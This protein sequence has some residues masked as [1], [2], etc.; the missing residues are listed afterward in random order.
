M[1]RARMLCLNIGTFH[2]WEAGKAFGFLRDSED[3]ASI[4]CHRDDIRTDDANFIA[5]VGFKVEFDTAVYDGRTKAVNVTLP[6]GGKITARSAGMADGGKPQRSV[7][8]ASNDREMKAILGV[9]SRLERR[10][11]DVSNRQ[12]ILFRAATAIAHK[13]DIVIDERPAAIELSKSLWSD[14]FAER[15]EKATMARES[16]AAEE[17]DNDIV[18]ESPSNNNKSKVVETDMF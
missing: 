8:H 15:R 5:P 2:R 10:V 4:F 13:E 1:F 16:E 11:R 18:K 9:V 3:G 14:V 6:G 7:S 12:Q 17:D